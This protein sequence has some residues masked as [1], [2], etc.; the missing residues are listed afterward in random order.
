MS[1]KKIYVSGFDD[2]QLVITFNLV[3]QYCTKNNIT[4]VILDSD[5]NNISP[6]LRRSKEYKEFKSKFNIIKF[7]EVKKKNLGKLFFYLILNFFEIIK[8]S[9]NLNR[10]KLLEKKLNWF[11]CQINHSIWDS[12][13]L[14]QNENKLMPSLISKFYY[15]T[16]IFSHIFY[17]KVLKS[18]NVKTA[19]MGHLVYASKAKIAQFRKDKIKIIGHTSESYFELNSKKD[20]MWTIIDKDHIKHLNKKL[21]EKYTYKYWSKRLKGYGLGE[22]TRIASKSSNKFEPQDYKNI[23]MLHIFKDSPFNYIDRERIFSDYYEWVEKTLEIMCDSNERWIVRSHPNATRWGEDSEKI[24]KLIYDKVCLKM[25]RKPNIFLDKKKI[26]NIDIFKSA[27]KIVTFSGT[28]HI[29][30]VCFGSKTIIISDVTLSVISKNLVLK[31]KNL[32]EYKN[33]IL[34][35]QNKYKFKS[36]KL[37][38]DFA[39]KILFI[40]EN[41]LSFQKQLNQRLIYRNDKNIKLIRNLNQNILMLKKKDIKLKLYNSFDYLDT[42]FKRTFSWEYLKL[43]KKKYTL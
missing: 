4:D 39:K 12:C 26:S 8:I 16:V 1:N 13:Y 38:S 24:F 6:L 17:A 11:D 36:N 5:I 22:D 10:K 34:N 35:K 15:S 27:N 20:M 25:Q 33:L 31:P 43:F 14:F 18:L 30:A 9:I 40:T 7:K 21:L 2:A 29:E 28:P 19:F 37:E 3:T 32:S 42:K 23:M 41:T